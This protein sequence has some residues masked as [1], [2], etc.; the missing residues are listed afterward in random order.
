MVLSYILVGCPC[1]EVPL[2][3]HNV[4]VIWDLIDYFASLL[5]TEWKLFLVFEV[6]NIWEKKL[7]ILTGEGKTLFKAEV[8]SQS[9][10]LSQ[11]IVCRV[12][13]CENG[14]ISY[15]SYRKKGKKSTI[16]FWSFFWISHKVEKKKVSFSVQVAI[17]FRRGHRKPI[18]HTDVEVIVVE[19]G[20]F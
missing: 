19:L 20:E 6:P 9:S 13:K 10:I 1:I 11:L 16:S 4:W 3:I 8:K 14:R 5:T 7:Q 2:Y 15:D 18:M 17:G 12:K